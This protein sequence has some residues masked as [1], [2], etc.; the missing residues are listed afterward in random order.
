MGGRVHTT[1][2]NRSQQIINRSSIITTIPSKEFTND[3]TN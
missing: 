1:Y 3:P 2:L